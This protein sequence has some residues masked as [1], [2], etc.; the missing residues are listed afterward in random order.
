[1]NP[2]EI[3]NLLT[4]VLRCG[5]A[6][7]CECGESIKFS[8]TRF[9]MRDVNE[10]ASFILEHDQQ[11]HKWHFGKKGESNEIAIAR[12]VKL[13]ADVRELNRINSALLKARRIQE[14]RLIAQSGIVPKV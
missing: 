7:T 10:L 8:G 14:A 13:K 5:E 3:K 1:M 6:T 11:G 4:D 12:M 2:T 9:D